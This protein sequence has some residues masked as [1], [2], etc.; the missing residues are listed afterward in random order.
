VRSCAGERVKAAGCRGGASFAGPGL[1]GGEEAG[2]DGVVVEAAGAPVLAPAVGVGD[3][4]VEP[5]VGAWSSQAG[6]WL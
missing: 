1:V 3:G 4:G 2:E 6:R 5:G